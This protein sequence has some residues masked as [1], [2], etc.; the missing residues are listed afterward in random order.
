MEQN[1]VL[2]KGIMPALVSPIDDD[3]NVLEDSM[4][5]LIRMHLSA[6]VT[7]FYLTGGTGEGC[8]L[9]P[10]TRMKLIET[11]KDEVGDKAKLIAHIGAIDLKTATKLA[12]H[13]ADTGMDAIS[14][15]PPFFFDYYEKEI[16]EYYKALSDAS[17]LPIIMYA[18]PAA[19]IEITYDMVK[20][21]MEIPNM[22][23]VKWTNYN[24]YTMHR[25]KEI[26]GGNINIINGP[27]ECL[28]CGLSMGADG[29]I[30]STYNVMPKVI[31]D[32][33]NKFTAGDIKGAQAA[34]FKANKL[35]DIIIKHDVVCSIKAL[36]ADM[37]F[38]CGKQV[39]PQKRFDNDEL[40][41]FRKEVKALK[42][43]E[44]Y[45]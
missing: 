42:F 24:Y 25:M 5:R 41:V 22:I 16:G 21:Y 37:G 12:R 10:S 33:Y 17:G 45:L 18:S 15:V 31:V 20:R 27:D 7:G 29:G 3:E 9:Q 23:G 6:G 19:G 26:N 30:G 35:I 11:A 32:I 1:K 36:L 39:Y 8:V 4:R 40:E 44:E 28:L 14:S 13:A 38:D 2:F 34:Q 43:E